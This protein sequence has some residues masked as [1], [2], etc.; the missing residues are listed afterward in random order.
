MEQVIWSQDLWRYYE[1]PNK[2]LRQ[3]ILSYTGLDKFLY[4]KIGLTF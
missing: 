2:K 3:D 1:L 4:P